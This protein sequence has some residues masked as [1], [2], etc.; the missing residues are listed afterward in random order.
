MVANISGELPCLRKKREFLLACIA[1][2]VVL[3]L[4]AFAG[5]EAFCSNIIGLESY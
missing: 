5:S 3:L 2:P 4:R 1:S